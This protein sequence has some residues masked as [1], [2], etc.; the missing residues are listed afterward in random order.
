[1]TPHVPA[2]PHP[3]VV[4]FTPES[5]SLTARVRARIPSRSR[6]RVC[7]RGPSLPV[8][9]LTPEAQQVHEIGRRRARTIWAVA[10][11]VYL[12]A[13][14][15][16][17]SLGVAGLLAADRF[18]INATQLAAFTVL[19]LF[20]YAAMQIPTGVLLDRFGPRRILLTGLVLM[21]IGQLAF[22][23]AEAFPV[24]VA[25]RAVLGSGDAMIFV[26]V[27]RLVAVWFLVK[28]A[29]GVAQLTGQLG[30]LGGVLAA[31]PLAWMLHQLG[32]TATFALASSIGVVL[33][34]AVALLVKDSPYRLTGVVRVKMG[35]LARSVRSIWGNPGTRLGLWSHFTSQ[36]S[37]TV[38]TLLW[39]YPFLVAGEGLSTGVAS[40]LLM[41]VTV[42]VFVS[43]SVLAR[44]TTRYPF[45]RSYIV[46]TVVGLMAA[47]WTVVL[48]LPEPAPPWLLVVLVFVMAAGGPASM[49]GFD[50]ARTFHPVEA[51][52][53]ANGLVN[54]G[55]F[56]A[57]LLTMAAI[58]VVLD[59][60]EPRGADF[61]TL[62]DFRVAWCAQYVFWAFGAAQILRYRKRA[63]AHMEREHPGA[64][65]NM[66]RGI[67]FVH[68]GI[69]D[70]EGV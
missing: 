37:V 55:G 61:Y 62:D 64:V 67:T 17:S 53:R 40:T 52:G 21:T 16:R 3:I 15:N 20:V 66:R 58:G 48:A 5:H 57:S 41:L 50:L 2:L 38:F 8:V 69:G 49:V 39:G 26:S 23:F 12:L 10:L 56:I 24:A 22:A 30:Q 60:L 45:Y 1:M 36:F 7:G 31:A 34:V 18:G 42:A 32:W 63:I 51:L 6:R 9:T 13:V 14:F 4:R 19:Q 59:V 33:M 29:P 47:V 11:T 25:A 65:E 28:Q 46:L 68:P 27:L 54:L 70:R 35:A 43:G 44:L